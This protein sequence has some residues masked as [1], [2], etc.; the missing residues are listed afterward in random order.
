[1]L[2][3]WL[4]GDERVASTGL[5]SR[6]LGRLWRGSWSGGSTLWSWLVF[7]DGRGCRLT[8]W[9]LMAYYGCTSILRVSCFGCRSRCSACSILAQGEPSKIAWWRCS[10]RYCGLRRITVHLWQPSQRP[11]LF[12]DGWKP[13][14]SQLGKSL[15]W[16]A[17]RMVHVWQLSFLV[18]SWGA[19][20]RRDPFRTFRSRQ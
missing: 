14:L 3:L 12:S 17:R 9:L 11:S 6:R 10:C 8:W 13:R 16:Q 7:R 4:G 1:M 15:L 18:V 2:G 5:F 19:R 20:C